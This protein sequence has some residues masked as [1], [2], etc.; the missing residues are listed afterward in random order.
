MSRAGLD[1]ARE[2]VKERKRAI[3]EAVSRA[4]GGG[5]EAGAGLGVVLGVADPSAIYEGTKLS[6]EE[7]TEIALDLQ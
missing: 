7:R 3:R 5:E 1:A 4:R 6:K 2:I